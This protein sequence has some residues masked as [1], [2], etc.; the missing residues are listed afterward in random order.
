MYTHVEKHGRKGN[1]C[2]YLQNTSNFHRVSCQIQTCYVLEPVHVNCHY[3][4]IPLN[5]HSKMYAVTN[6]TVVALQQ[7][8]YLFTCSSVSLKELSFGFLCAGGV[9]R[10]YYFQLRQYQISHSPLFLSVEGAGSGGESPY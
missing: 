8:R 1:C 5:K 10:Y 7:L 3:Q 2:R 6:M 9:E 4:F